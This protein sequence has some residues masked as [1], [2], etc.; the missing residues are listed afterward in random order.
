MFLGSFL[1]GL[2]EGLEAALIIGILIAY[3]RRE[4]R[5]DLIGRIWSGVGVAVVVSLGLGALFTYGR[6]GLSF[7]GQEIIGG[8]LSL[9]AVAMVTWMVFWMVTAGGGI[10]GEL[11]ARAGAGLASGRGWALFWIALVSVGREGIETTLMLW[12]WALQPLALTG[13]LLGI[14]AAA[15]L[16]YLIFAGMIRM[17]LGVFFR[18]TGLLLI[19]VAAGILAYGVHDLQ[20]AGILPGPF[21]GHPVTPTDLRTG[22]VLVGLTDGPFWMASFPFGWAFDLSAAMDPAGVVAALL[23][24][25]VGFV[26]QMSWI[27]VL[28]W[29]L[30]IGIVAP[31]FIRLTFFSHRRRH[32]TPQHRPTP[33]ADAATVVTPNAPVGAAH[34]TAI[35]T[36]GK[37]PSC[38]P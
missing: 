3:L 1:I 25:T 19:V 22:D 31:R 27:E 2:R 11:E 13:A 4:G 20:E 33:A 21:S 30:Y 26:P 36:Q 18:W 17:N 5:G 12:G 15:G 10:K 23:K 28:A 9:I 7:A 32:S 38:T 16:G 35:S 37:E 6:H 14:L 34:P 24:G 29:A 8:T